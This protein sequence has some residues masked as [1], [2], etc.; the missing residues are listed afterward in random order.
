MPYSNYTKIETNKTNETKE[1]LKNET[2][3][4]ATVLNLTLNWNNATWYIRSYWES[5]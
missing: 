2:I 3:K 4:I 5:I 1:F